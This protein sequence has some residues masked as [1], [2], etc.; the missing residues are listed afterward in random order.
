MFDDEDS[1][2]WDDE[3]DEQ[4]EPVSEPLDPEDDD[5][6]EPEPGD[7]WIETDDNGDD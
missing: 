5:E 6:A 2:A 4:F 7:F 3:S 1:D